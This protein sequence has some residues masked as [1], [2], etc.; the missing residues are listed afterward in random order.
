MSKNLSTNRHAI[1][2]VKK[3]FVQAESARRRRGADVAPAP[4]PAPRR[5]LIWL[6]MPQVAVTHTK[7]AGNV[8]GA[9]LGPAECPRPSHQPVGSSGA[10]LV[11]PVA[12]SAPRCA[13][14]GAKVPRSHMISRQ[15]LG[16]FKLGF[17]TTKPLQPVL[18]YEE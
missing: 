5:S 8:L 15:L 2:R 13:G 1:W 10:W 7:E 4:F 11:S 3:L 14:V 9:A 18:L 6:L 12:G 16:W 17:S